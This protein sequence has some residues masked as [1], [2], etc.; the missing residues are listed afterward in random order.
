M[1]VTRNL[2]GL[3]ASVALAL[4]IGGLYGCATPTGGQTA[5]AAKATSATVVATRRLTESQYRNTIAD[6]F[7]ADIEM[8]ARFEPDTREHGLL[9]IG[10]SDLS[11]TSG[12][13]E[14]YFAMAR[15]VADQALDE[16]RRDKFATCKPADVT[17]ADDKCAA[18]FIRH[19][20]RRLFRRPLTDV[21]VASRVKLA[22]VGA[23]QN[24][25]YYAGVKLALTSLLSS[26]EY[27]FRVESAERDPANRRSERLD[28]YT[29]AQRLSYLMWD[30]TPDEELLQAAASGEIHT[31]A[32]LDKQIARLSASP[33]LEAGVRAVFSDM[34]QFDKF[35]TVTKDPAT[36]P[37]FSAGIANS[38]REQTLKTLVHQ[39]VTQQGDY[40]DIF[41]SPDTFVDR[42]LASVYQV[43]FTAVS[44]WAPYRYPQT[45]DQAGVLTQVTFLSLFSHP[46]RSS[47]T[48]RGVALNEIFLCEE[49]PLPPANIDFSIVQDTTNPL[50]KTV[51]TRL[52]AHATDETCAGCHNMTDPIGLSLERFD[53]IGQPRE[54]ENGELIDVTSEL[55]GV[56]FEGAL[57]LGK[58]LRGNTRIAHCVVRNV[59][60]YGVGR[61]PTSD[62]ERAYLDAQTKA[63]ADDGYKLPAMIRRVAAS[64][65]F[66]RIA[67][68]KAGAADLP[69]DPTN[70]AEQA[71]F[72]LAGGSQ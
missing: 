40:R 21:E 20:G 8:T 32:G 14:Q 59:Y 56:K 47:P 7:G 60:A 15:S 30:T 72:K 54:R 64:P 36:Y 42:S 70:V 38:A 23:T 13:F 37:K 2:A 16:K 31:A 1:A 66:Y 18:D 45:A 11:I 24:K 19:Y 43:P 49:T 55:D 65:D 17:T 34:L 52:L 69:K 4:S 3:S 10:S 63:F 51:R 50:L 53:S 41:T 46:G 61:D 58:V 12:G 29:K 35:E 57:G 68:P 33:R 44:G 27:L 71:S 48:K 22:N 26:P 28:A 5:Q 67:A 6:L 39:L 62:W 25:A 9:A